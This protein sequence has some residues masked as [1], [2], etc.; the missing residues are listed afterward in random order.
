MYR[1][2]NGTWNSNGRNGKQ[3]QSKNNPKGSYSSTNMADSSSLPHDSN[4]SDGNLVQGFTAEQI[5]QL[6][7]AFYSLNNNYGKS[8]AF[9]NA[10]GLFAH[11]SSINSAFTKPWILDS[12]TNHITFDSQFF[13][14]T[15]SSFIPNVNLLSGSTTTISSTGTIK[16]NENITLKDVLCVL[17]FNLNLMSVSKITSVLNCCVVL[18]PHGCV[19]QDLATRRMIDS[20]K[21]YAGL[22]Y[23]SPLQNQARASQV[24]ANPD[25]WH[26]CLRH[27]SLTRLQLVS[28][29][30]PINKNSISIHNNCSIC[31]KA[32]QTRLPFPLST[33]KSHSHLIYYIVTFGVLIKP[34]LILENVFFS[35]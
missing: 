14:H 6:A 11:N 8:E 30:L 32:K 34:R 10:A 13:T 25:L 19:L 2:K 3:Q 7:K 9:I 15:S 18:F 17:S 5:Q 16:F 12:R 22:Y 20:G 21:Q 24:S 35:L 28:S 4:K 1:I 27:P 26:K 31:P 23:M 29:L 33:I